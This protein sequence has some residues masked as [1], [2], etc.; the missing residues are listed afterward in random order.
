MS[1]LD[2]VDENGDGVSSSHCLT[3]FHTSGAHTGREGACSICKC[4]GYDPLLDL[5]EMA[6]E[7]EKEAAR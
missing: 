3:C 1:L 2:E 7:R 4:D 5:V 6:H